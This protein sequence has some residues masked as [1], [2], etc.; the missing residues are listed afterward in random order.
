MEDE[1]IRA[2]EVHFL[3]PVTPNGVVKTEVI[4]DLK[5]AWVTSDDGEHHR[6]KH[7]R[8]ENLTEPKVVTSASVRSY[9]DDEGV[10]ER[11]TACV[12]KG[13]DYL[14]E[15][16]YYFD[17]RFRYSSYLEFVKYR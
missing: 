3:Y 17:A 16:T 5:F 4:E 1:E 8:V 13:I 11:A 10:N 14:V 7:Y 9:A 15:H 2:K 6:D 12:K